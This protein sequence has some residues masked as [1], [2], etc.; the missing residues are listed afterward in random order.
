ML[1]LL[2]VLQVPWRS[3]ATTIC[4]FAG[5][6]ALRCYNYCMFCMLRCAPVLQLLNVL[7]IPW[8]SGATTIDFCR[9]CGAPMLQLLNVLQVQW[10]SGATTI[11]CFACCVALRC[12]NHRLF[13][14]F[15]G[16][17]MLQLYT[18]FTLPN[19]AKAC[20]PTLVFMTRASCRRDRA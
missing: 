6:V 14:M 19:N 2:N 5:S 4:N 18:L 13:C 7:Q 3:G 15:R 20:L 17:P 9:F 10:R 8:R 11:E 16:A 12:Y 1:Q